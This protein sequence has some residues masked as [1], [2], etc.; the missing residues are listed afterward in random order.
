MKR[1]RAVITVLVA[2]LFPMLSH[3]TLVSYGVEYTG[4]WDIEGGGALSGTLITGES[5][6]DDGIIDLGLE[7]EAWSWSWSGNSFVSAFSISS[8]DAGA[9]VDIFGANAGVFVDGTPN[10]PDFAD[11]LDQGV[12]IGGSFGEFVIDLE[13]LFL[14][15]N[16]V[17]FPVGGDFTEG[18]IFSESGL[19]SVAPAQAVPAP[20]TLALLALALPGLLFF[21]KPGRSAA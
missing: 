9:G 13:Y 10:L 5:A 19:V 8:R 15:D 6:G 21:R 17:G 18:D 11:G 20:A 3:A 2:L 14:E 1:S 16:T 7:L 12:F 4:W